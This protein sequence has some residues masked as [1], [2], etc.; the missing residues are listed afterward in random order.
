MTEQLSLWGFPRSSVGKESACTA[1]DL[2][3]FSGS[4]R[5]PE[6]GNGNPLQYSC[7]KNP[8][9]KK[10]KR[11]PWTEEPGRLQ[12]LWSQESDTIERLKPP[13]DHDHTFWRFSFVKWNH[14]HVNKLL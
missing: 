13:P 12:F 2:G 10:K 6:E 7:L 9:K 14:S 3:S 4:R 5:S 11:I 1:G 8:M